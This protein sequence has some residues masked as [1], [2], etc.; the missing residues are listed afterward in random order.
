M[1]LYADTDITEKHT[2]TSALRMEA[3][4]SFE[5]WYCIQVHT[6]LQRNI[7]ISILKSY[8]KYKDFLENYFSLP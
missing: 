4:R 1:N 2:L 6:A 3:V 7:E 5:R 8:I